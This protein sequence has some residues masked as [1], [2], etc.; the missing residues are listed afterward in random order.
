MGLNMPQGCGLT[1]C[2]PFILIV[3]WRKV[4]CIQVYSYFTRK[5]PYK[6]LLSIVYQYT[7]SLMQCLCKVPSLQCCVDNMLDY[8]IQCIAQWYYCFKDHCIKCGKQYVIA[9]NYCWKEKIIYKRSM[10][11]IYSVTLWQY[12]YTHFSDVCEPFTNR[13]W[14]NTMMVCHSY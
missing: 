2:Q 4:S 5:E 10:C 12:S 7:Y 9:R 3:E 6:A 11:W 8:C 14:S 1:Q 13:N